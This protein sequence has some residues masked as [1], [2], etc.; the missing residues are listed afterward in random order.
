MSKKCELVEQCPFYNQ[1]TGNQEVRKKCWGPVF[2]W[3]HD[4]SQHCQRKLF[5]QENGQPPPPNMTPLGKMLNTSDYLTN[6]IQHQSD[7]LS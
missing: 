5:R 4:K 6:H 7:S 2:C 3:D 1:F